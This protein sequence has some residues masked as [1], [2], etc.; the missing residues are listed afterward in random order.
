MY[1]GDR[2]LRRFDILGFP[3]DQALSIPKPSRVIGVLG[4]IGSIFV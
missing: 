3:D 2:E 4:P 1:F